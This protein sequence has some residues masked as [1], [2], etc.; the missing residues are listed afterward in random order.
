MRGLPD[1]AP[2]VES[3]PLAGVASA[4]ELPG[5]GWGVGN[6][7]RRSKQ[8]VRESEDWSSADMFSRQQEILQPVFTSEDAIEG[9]T[10]FA[11]KRAPN[12]KGR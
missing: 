6:R 3:G 7:I 8:V 9:A 4:H 2:S 11:E 10:A 1:S 12:W 5:L